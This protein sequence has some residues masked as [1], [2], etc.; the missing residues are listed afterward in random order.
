MVK[1]LLNVDVNEVSIVG[2]GAVDANYVIY[3][4][5]D[6]ES[7]MTDIIDKE[8][9]PE[10]QEEKT[11]VDKQMPPW[12]ENKDK[13]VEETPEEKKKRLAEE[14]KMKKEEPV[15]DKEAPVVKAVIEAA[16]I[17]ADTKLRKEMDD[18]KKMVEERDAKL[19][20]MEDERLTK[21]FVEMAKE[22]PYAGKAD[23]FGLLLKEVSQK[24]PDA[25]KG[26]E[27]ALKGMTAQIKEGNLFKEV[28]KTPTSSATT[29]VGKVTELAKARV[30][31]KISLEK[32][33][34]QVLREN[35]KL[36]DEYRTET[37]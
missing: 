4:S 37:H 17:E 10:K 12:L 33:M 11:E 21:E 13:K 7:E 24:A 28:G 16:T 31:D 23:E 18:L 35:P 8:A 34:D 26:I 19:A 14:A 15:L 2:K 5:M 25:F 32:A 29:V 36:Y 3:K 9:K 6:E 20:K 1:R 27:M 22:Y 30:T